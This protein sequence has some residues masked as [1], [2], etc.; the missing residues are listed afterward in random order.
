[1]LVPVSISAPKKMALTDIKAGDYVGIAAEP[2]K[3][4][5]GDAMAMAVQVFPAAM[6]GTAEGSFG[7]DLTPTST[8]TNGNVD[9]EAK[10]VDGRVLTMSFKGKTAKLD[11]PEGTPVY[12]PV[13]ATA[14]D[15][16]TGAKVFVYG[17]K[18]A[19]GALSSNRVLVGKDGI[20]P[21]S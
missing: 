18:A 12:T 9:A 10:S 2:G 15:L 21:P 19:D 17:T 14:A 4:K 16:V 5:D 6:R 11:V 1:M 20:D 13:P 7:W 3:A 8:M